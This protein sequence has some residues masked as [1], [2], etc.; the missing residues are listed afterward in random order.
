M[1]DLLLVKGQGNYHGFD[2]GQAMICFWKAMLQKPARLRGHGISAVHRH[3]Y[4]HNFL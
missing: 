3:R 2:G 4:L 1:V